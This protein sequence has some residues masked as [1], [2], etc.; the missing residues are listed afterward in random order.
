LNSPRLRERIQSWE[1][2]GLNTSQI[3]PHDYLLDWRHGGF[4]LRYVHHFSPSELENLA[5]DT[6]FEIVDAFVSDGE[7]GNLGLY[8]VWQPV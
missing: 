4:G 3:D 8:Q 2:I 1:M 7:G 6:G 5:S